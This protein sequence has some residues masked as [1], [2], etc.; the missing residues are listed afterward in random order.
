MVWYAESTGN[1]AGIFSRG[2][3]PSCTPAN[4]LCQLLAA[5]KSLGAES[6]LTL[7]LLAHLLMILLFWAFLQ[8]LPTV[9]L[10]DLGAERTVLVYIDGG[11]GE[12][13]TRLVADDA[14]PTL[15]TVLFGHY[16]CRKN[17]EKHI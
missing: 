17:V 3:P 14:G 6:G 5:L 15:M 1:L 12:A 10:Y 7:L 9:G 16:Y 2:E 8:T 4:L 11:R 13:D